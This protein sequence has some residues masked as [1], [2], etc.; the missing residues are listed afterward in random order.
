M[1]GRKDAALGLLGL[2]LMTG[3]G[4]PSQHEQVVTS[5]PT[6]AANDGAD[7]T[8]L[9][10][11]WADAVH[12]AR[13]YVA[14]PRDSLQGFIESV[15]SA[16]WAT[17]SASS[18]PSAPPDGGAETALTLARRALSAG[19]P[20]ASMSDVVTLVLALEAR[21]T[22]VPRDA[23]CLGPEVGTMQLGVLVGLASFGA[24]VRLVVPRVPPLAW[25]DGDGDDDTAPPH[26]YAVPVPPGFEALPWDP[27]HDGVLARRFRGSA[28]SPYEGAQ[29]MARAP[30]A[31]LGARVEASERP[32]ACEALDALL[33]GRAEDEPLATERTGD[34]AASCTRAGARHLAWVESSEQPL[35]WTLVVTDPAQLPR[36]RMAAELASTRAWPWFQGH[37]ST[38][39]QRGTEE[40][41]RALEHG[42]LLPS[43]PE[44][45]GWHEEHWDTGRPGGEHT[46]FERT[47]WMASERPGWELSRVRTAFRRPSGVLVGGGDPNPRGRPVTVIPQAQYFEEPSP[48]A[49]ARAVASML[50]RCPQL[51]ALS[52]H[53]ILPSPACDEDE[54][55]DCRVNDWGTVRVF[56]RGWS[57]SG[58]DGVGEWTQTAV[59]LGS[60]EARVLRAS[61]QHLDPYSGYA[62]WATSERAPHPAHF[63]DFDAIPWPAHAR[64]PFPGG[65]TFTGRPREQD[66]ARVCRPEL[67]FTRQRLQAGPWID[68]VP[69][70]VPARRVQRGRV[71]AVP[72]ELGGTARENGTLHVRLRFE[73][74]LR[75]GELVFYTSARHRYGGERL[76][77]YDAGRNQHRMLLDSTVPGV[78]GN[79]QVH[80]VVGDELILSVTPDPRPDFVQLP[81]Y[82][83]LNLE[84]GVGRTLDATYLR[85]TP[86][87]EAAPNASSAPDDDAFVESMDEA[88]PGEYEAPWLG[89][90]FVRTTDGT[91]EVVVSEDLY[92][93]E[94]HRRAC[95][96]G[97]PLATLV[98][99]R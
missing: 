62:T 47:E 34:G 32:L 76:A 9:P 97:T 93:A 74:R 92:D 33:A 12:A 40:T 75:H 37:P 30:E 16:G 7:L 77:V 60:C 52:A 80:D 23:V 8:D 87:P 26:G 55:I 78:R 45:D 29:A 21:C 46:V 88:Q 49:Y 50:E 70:R 82:I 5:A 54:D 65:P 1:N 71:G 43:L 10:P 57:G 89:D 24:D 96:R 19:P 58:M 69:D 22:T 20:P 28:G 64:I 15:M 17:E 2:V 13:A 85:S 27:R 31:L 56:E 66:G 94:D 99:R 72:R 6:A 73:P 38:G 79:I 42:D 14:T 68:G 83:V 3:C 63:A 44:A 90:S 39:A 59:D 86:S 25:F 48:G 81:V 4:A 18:A 67:T 98:S 61:Y 35:L 95:I 51:A 53:T 91:P 36:A 41:V 11:A 84:S